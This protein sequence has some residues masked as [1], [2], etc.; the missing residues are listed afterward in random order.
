M[1]WNRKCAK[2]FFDV[3]IVEQYVL[4]VVESNVPRGWIWPGNR[5]SP[6]KKFAGEAMH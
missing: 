1:V 2:R 6:V 5:R 3:V 4:F